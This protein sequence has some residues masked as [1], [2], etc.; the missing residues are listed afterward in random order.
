MCHS[1]F[2]YALA[3]AIHQQWMLSPLMHG[4]FGACTVS[5]LSN[6]QANL[7]MESAHR[8]A[9]LPMHYVAYSASE[10]SVILT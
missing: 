5:Y 10:Q 6:I 1:P 9:G 7:C 8:K 3:S 4:S 2:W